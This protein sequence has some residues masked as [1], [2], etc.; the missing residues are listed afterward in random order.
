M[1]CRSNHASIYEKYLLIIVLL[2]GFVTSC[3]QEERVVYVH[4]GDTFILSS[5]VRIRLSQVDA[6]ELGQPYGMEA[7]QVAEKLLLNKTIRIHI[8]ERD[9]YHRPVADVYTDQGENFAEVL[10]VNGLAHTTPWT[11][12]KR[13]RAEYLVAKKNN[14]GLFQSSYEYPYIYRRKHKIK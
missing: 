11:T 6:P 9:E 2:L 4:D 7:K 14:I 10:I 3:T 1:F 13:L 5:G 8:R 12:N